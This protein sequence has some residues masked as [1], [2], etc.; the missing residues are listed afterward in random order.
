MT[1][2]TRREFFRASS[3]ATIGV[4]SQSAAVGGAPQ[5]VPLP[6]IRRFKPFGKTGW[7]V[8]DISAG[9]GQNDPALIDHIFQR[10]VNLIDS[11]F[12]YGGHEETLGK[13]LPKWREKVFVITKWDT[14]LVSPT[15]TKAA[16]L[17][18]LDISLKRLNTKYVD[19]LMIHSIGQPTHG[20]RRAGAEVIG[21]I[22]RIQNP[23]IY[24]AWDEAKRLKKVRFTGASSH[25]V[26]VIEE[27]GWGVDN[28][29][30]E[31]ILVGANFLTH[32]IEPVLKRARAKGVATIA[33]KTMT[34]YRSDL[35]IRALQGPQTNARQACVKWVLA[36][37]LFDTVALSMRN[38]DQVN[39][40]LPVSGTTVLSTEDR[41]RL[42]AMEAAVSHLYCRP[43]CDRCLGSC[44]NGVPIWDI[45]RYRMY[46]EHYGDE[47]TAMRQYLQVPA[48]CNASLCEHCAA[49]CERTCPYGLQIRRRLTEAHQMLTLT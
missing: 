5:A 37:D 46:F 10:G 26:H 33:M 16:L 13:I 31:V 9:S 1:K 4:A 23:A 24:E 48:A 49:P 47:K 2:F 36:S 41:D 8:S 11:A 15:V 20:A 3:L 19:C 30:F 18:G 45:L 12:A 29:R 27:M 28:D 39:E 32:G 40:Y 35:N 17:E 25:G 43:G 44:R 38:Y 6:R 7:S 42:K 34:I 14:S 21:G 22:E